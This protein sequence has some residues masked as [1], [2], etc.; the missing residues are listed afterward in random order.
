MSIKL[1]G[2]RIFITGAGGLLGKTYIKSMLESGAEVIAT[3]LPGKRSQDLIDE[4]GNIPGFNFFNL[5]V[6]SENE[7]EKVFSNLNKSSLIPNVF[8]NNAAIT[9]ELL[10]GQGKDFPDFSQTNLADW[11]KAINVNL[12]GAFLIAR[13]IDRDFVKKQEISLIN[14]ASMYALNAPHHEIYNDLPFKSFSAYSA[15]KAGIH[16]LTLWLSS[17]WSESNATVN[18]IAPGAVYNDHSTIFSD[19]VSKLIIKKRMAEPEEIANVMLF[20]CSDN[21]KYIT[22]QIINVDGGFSAW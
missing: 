13:Q 2:K 19:R 18:T 3:E 8:I 4:F 14:V 6:T 16:G 11:N 1:E 21:A 9:G 17:Y 12:T 10:L 7:I 15:S 22:G 5:D 20:L